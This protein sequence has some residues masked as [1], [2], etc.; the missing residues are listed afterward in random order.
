MQKVSIALALVVILGCVS[1]ID[2][3]TTV[4]KSAVS[5]KTV[6][7]NATNDTA[8]LNSAAIDLVTTDNNILLIGKTVTGN[9]SLERSFLP[10]DLS[11]VK[12]NDTTINV[13]I[14]VNQI[15]AFNNYVKADVIV[16]GAS[17]P[18]ITITLTPYIGGANVTTIVTKNLDKTVVYAIKQVFA[19]RNRYYVVYSASGAQ[20]NITGVNNKNTDVQTVVLT[21]NATTS[22]PG[23]SCVGVSGKDSAYCVF[24]ALKNQTVNVTNGT[25]NATNGTANATNGTTNATNGTTN[26][27]NGTTNATNGTANA[28]NATNGTANATNATNSTVNTTNTT[29]ASTPSIVVA[30]RM[31]AANV[32]NV[33]NA[34]NATNTTNITVAHLVEVVVALTGSSAVPTSDKFYKGFQAN[35][36]P[37]VVKVFNAGNQYGAI[38]N[39]NNTWYLKNNQMT[40]VT[41]FTAPGD[42]INTILPNKD[43]AVAFWN[44]NN[45]Q[46]MTAQSIDNKGGLNSAQI[47]GGAQKISLAQYKDG[48]VYS[49]AGNTTVG[50]MAQ[51]WPATGLSASAIQ[52]AFAVVFVAVASLFLF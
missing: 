24:V 34:T 47:I 36:T 38:V 18:Q 22:F 44:T 19:H 4:W 11:V 32:T 52:S 39:Y 17:I 40:N 5:V 43:V 49:F 13:S 12:A 8:F 45:N 41:N 28:T 21:N 37:T 7:V 15:V 26:A 10:K 9:G 29:N 1:A 14:S 33:T 3:N 51:V 48:S 25:A 20:V 30:K 23:V 50:F 2:V 16:D 35:F 42:S 6:L 31:L 46:N 27:T